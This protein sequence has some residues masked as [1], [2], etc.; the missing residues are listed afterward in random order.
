MIKS[1]EGTAIFC[2]EISRDIWLSMK[3]TRFSFVG[4]KID[5]L[6]LTRTLIYEDPQI[7]RQYEVIVSAKERKA[8]K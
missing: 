3:K 2:D 6:T 7:G 1:M 5:S 8:S 4:L